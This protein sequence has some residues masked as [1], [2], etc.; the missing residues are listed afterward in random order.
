MSGALERAAVLGAGAW[1]TTVASLLAPRVP[2]TLW[3]RSPHIAREVCE[4]RTNAL[5][6]G[7]CPLSPSLRA[8]AVLAEALEGASLVVVAVPSHGFRDV[9]TAGA[10]YVADGATVLS[11]TKGLE[12]ESLARMTEIVGECWPDRPSGVLGGPNLASEVL[13]GQPTASVVALQDEALAK[14]VQALLSSESLR[15][16]RN[17]DVVGCEIAGAVKNVLAIASGMAAGLGFGDNTRAALVTRSLAELARLGTAL[18]GDP[19][20]FAG[21]AGLGDLVA[22]CTSHSSRNFAVGLGLGRGFSL[23][24]ALASVS[25]VAEGVLGCRPVLELASRA[26]VEVPVAEQV[27]AVCHEGRAPSSTIA[28]LMLRSGKSE[29]D[30][31]AAR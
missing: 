7:A 4:A 24:S 20:T 27:V 28:Q 1:G 17:T 6:T 13:A 9:L 11:L 29:L 5:Y 10:G 26:G 14:E 3:A 23:E 8:S 19:Q 16:Y 22:T 2:T 25:G 15:V 30:G 21:L 18:G 31:P 12:R